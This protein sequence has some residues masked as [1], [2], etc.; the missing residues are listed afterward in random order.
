[1][2]RGKASKQY[3]R[4]LWGSPV[5]LGPVRFADAI[6]AC[7]Q[8]AFRVVVVMDEEVHD[9]RYRTVFAFGIIM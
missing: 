8:A 7:Q 3:G 6:C 4:Y 1:M 2:H 5:V 9:A